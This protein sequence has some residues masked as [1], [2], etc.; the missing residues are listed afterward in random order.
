MLCINL[1]QVGDEIDATERKLREI[2][3]E[4]Y[5]DTMP[6]PEETEELRPNP[7]GCQGRPGCPAEPYLSVFNGEGKPR[8]IMCGNCSHRHTEL[9]MQ[10][11]GEEK[12]HE[13]AL[14]QLRS[15]NAEGKADE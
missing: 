5:K 11:R 3:K 10:F 7:R 14:A 13:K 9:L 12:D 8:L 4:R 2:Q 6:S 1:I 15:E